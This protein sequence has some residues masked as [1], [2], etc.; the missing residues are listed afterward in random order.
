MDADAIEA[1]HL[2]AI[3]G[4]ITQISFSIVLTSEIK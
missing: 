2:L 4:D 1:T 3:T